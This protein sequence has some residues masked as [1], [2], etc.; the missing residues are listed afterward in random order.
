MTS[1]KL[2]ACG[3]IECETPEG[4]KAELTLPSKKKKRRKDEVEHFHKR[5]GFKHVDLGTF[6]LKF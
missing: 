4:K 1:K 5:D 6:L 2:K 3:K